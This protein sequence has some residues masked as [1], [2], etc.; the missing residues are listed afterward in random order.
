MNPEESVNM[1]E[2][3]PRRSIGL[4]ELSRHIY[5]SPIPQLKLAN[6]SPINNEQ[7]KSSLPDLLVG[8]KQIEESP[9]LSVGSKQAGLE[10]FLKNN[11]LVLTPSPMMHKIYTQ[12]SDLTKEPI[13]EF[14]NENINN[15]TPQIQPKTPKKHFQFY[16]TPPKEAKINCCNHCTIKCI[17]FQL[18]II[19][20][21]NYIAIELEAIY[22]LTVLKIIALSLMLYALHSVYPTE[23]QFDYILV[24]NIFSSYAYGLSIIVL[25]YSKLLLRKDHQTNSKFNDSA[26]FF[27]F[28]AAMVL[29]VSGFISV[30]IIIMYEILE[31]EYLLFM[32]LLI[33]I[34]ITDTLGI[35][36]IGAPFLVIVAVEVMVYMCIHKIIMWMKPSKSQIR[37]VDL[38]PLIALSKCSCRMKD[39]EGNTGC[40]TCSICLEDF[41]GRE[42]I[43][44]MPCSDDH[45]FH[46]SCIRKWMK[47][48]EVCPT[49]RAE[50]E[51]EESNVSGNRSRLAS[52]VQ[53]SL[54]NVIS[55]RRG[56]LRLTPIPSGTLSALGQQRKSITTH[57]NLYTNLSRGEVPRE[58]PLKHN[59]SL[60]ERLF[61]NATPLGGGGRVFM[62]QLHLQG[63]DLDT[64][65]RI[66]FFHHLD[67]GEGDEVQIEEQKEMGRSNSKYSLHQ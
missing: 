34:S 66:N 14:P 27:Y 49:C 13:P 26:F 56:T 46:L 59:V 17:E 53:Y 5:D 16:S 60:G 6:I 23:S 62:A 2:S 64:H 38:P 51:Y 67:K 52:S 1:E 58:S 61:H 48:N 25:N 57:Y 41:R 7:P 43:V 30:Y 45:I 15:D 33:L 63:T 10:S 22:Q 28:I 40:I 9:P 50:F 44:V 35:I 18:R 65:R 4:N 42:R 8:S 54:S 11:P 55:P 3:T 31:W 19:E 36:I 37:G 32:C 20:K 24:V 21:V 12:R 29:L 39:M 47:N